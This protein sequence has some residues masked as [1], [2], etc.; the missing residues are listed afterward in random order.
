[1]PVVTDEDAVNEAIDGFIVLGTLSDTSLYTLP[2][3]TPADVYVDNSTTSV[4]LS[5][6]DNQEWS[7]LYEY[8]VVVEG[9]YSL[10]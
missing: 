8:L 9:K 6:V 2:T 1:M 5:A 4:L 3:S 10:V 7:I